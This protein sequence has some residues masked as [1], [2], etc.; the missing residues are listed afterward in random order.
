MASVK[1]FIW[2]RDLYAK[3]L[4]RGTDYTSNLVFPNDELQL[5][6]LTNEPWPTLNQ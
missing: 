2:K 3:T 4:Q 6:N 1:D 5:Q